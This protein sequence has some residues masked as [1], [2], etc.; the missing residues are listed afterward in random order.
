MVARQRRAGAVQP[1][2]G[3]VQQARGIGAAIESGNAAFLGKDVI[4]DAAG[5]A[6][7]LINDKGIAGGARALGTLAIRGGD[8]A[9]QGGLLDAAQAY[10]TGERVSLAAS[11][12]YDA[13]GRLVSR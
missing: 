5:G 3:N 7:R 6:V 1:F 9:I 11:A 8:I 10:L 13:H 2:G 12:R 4:L